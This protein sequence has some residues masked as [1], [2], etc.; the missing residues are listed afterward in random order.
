MKTL[1]T[2][3]L[4][5]WAWFGL[6]LVQ[7]QERPPAPSRPKIAWDME[8]WSQREIDSY[9][10]KYYRTID[11]DEPSRSHEGVTHV[12]KGAV[13]RMTE[14]APTAIEPGRFTCVAPLPKVSGWIRIFGVHPQ[15]KEGYSSAPIH[16]PPGLAR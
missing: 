9:V 11:Q 16:I 15:L 7:M 3:T 5:A 6:A 13:C 2:L 10:W 4:V 12:L 14:L 8:A 1:I